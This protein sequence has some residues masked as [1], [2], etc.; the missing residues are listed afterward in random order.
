[1]LVVKNKTKMKLNSSQAIIIFGAKGDLTK[2]KLI[3]AFYNL[4]LTN[5]LAANFSIY[6][7]DYIATEEAVFKKE[8]R[9]ALDE[10]SRTGKTNDATWHNFESK[11]HYIQGDFTKEEIFLSLK[12]TLQQFDRDSKSK[13]TRLFFYSIAPRFIEIVS[14]GLYNHKLAS[15]TANHRIIIE[16]PFG[17][18]Y[19]TAKKLNTFLLKKFEEKQIFRIDHYLGKETVQNILAFR[20]ANNIFEPLWNNK[21][22]DHIQITVA[23]KVSVGSRGGYYDQAGAIKDMIQNHLLQLLCVIAMESPNAYNPTEIRN[24]K[25]QVLKQVKPFT[26]TIV[27]K[28]VIRAQYKA[29]IINNQKQIGYKEELNI[30]KNSITETYFAAKFSIDNKRWKGVPF[31]IRTGKCLTKQTSVIT[32]LF[33]PTKGK[34]FKEDNEPNKLVIAIQPDNEISLW[35]ESKIPGLEMKLKNV[36]MDFTYKESYTESSPEAY[37][38]LLLDALEGDATLFMRADQVEAAWKVVMPIL[39]TWKAQQTNDLQYYTAGT[40]GPKKADDLMKKDNRKWLIN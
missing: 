19:S 35:F 15:N 2:R 12:N 10:F 9:Q 27:E 37:E 4:N 16:K 28:N 22:I 6:C 14:A 34:I 32:I 25:L 24:K 31:Y 3:P 29:G 7:V 11:L 40:L 39:D 17:T 36:E 5:N 23:E 33:K 38:A 26:K 30:P 20:F 13:A 8:I 21:H 18:D 1:V